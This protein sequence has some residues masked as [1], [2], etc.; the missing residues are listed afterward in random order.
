LRLLQLLRPRSAAGIC[1]T[2]VLMSSLLLHGSDAR[3]LQA[4]S[5]SGSPSSSRLRIRRETGDDDVRQVVIKHL[6]KY[7]Y[8]PST[9][10]S[11]EDLRK[12]LRT[13]QA[14]A[15]V[16]VTGEVD[17]ETLAA[18]RMKRCSRP[19][20]EISGMSV[21]A[22]RYALPHASKWNPKHFSGH[23]LTLKWFISKYT[24]DMDKTATKKTIQRGFEV[25]SKQTHIP[26]F[27]DK[28]HQVTLDFEEAKSEGE[29]DI[30]IRW[31]EGHHGDKFPFDGDG[32]ENENVLAHTFYPDYKP[33]PLNGDIHFD[34]AERWSLAVGVNTFFPYVLVHEIGHALG[35]QHSHTSLAIM[36]PHYK[37]IPIESMHLHQDDKCGINWN[38]AG[39]TNWCLF[40]WLTSEVVPINTQ[41]SG[42]NPNKKLSKIEKLFS[43]K[44]Q[45]WNAQLPLC[46]SDNSIRGDLLVLLEK[47]L[48]FSEADAILYAEV[49]CRFL[50]GLD[51][52]REKIGDYAHKLNEDIARTK[53]FVSTAEDGKQLSRRALHRFAADKPSILDEE[54]FSLDFFDSFFA[55]Y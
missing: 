37:D 33:Y 45:L 15:G 40:V 8:L 7:A 36:N 4:N 6:H 44:K 49:C 31:E 21:R 10:P 11:E 23:K 54:H 38:I 12:A 19:D 35:L 16:P 9:E 1:C 30:N 41:T 3:S 13:Y 24:S 48:H 14:V 46:R 34:D 51:K 25:W 43:I 17:A 47:N 2:L 29:A 53:E 39:P 22:K 55:D 42:V 5:R 50:E 28:S 20:A 32:D 18:T 52:Y 27:T 26:Q